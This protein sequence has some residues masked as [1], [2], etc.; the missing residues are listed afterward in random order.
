[1]PSKILQMI[2]FVA[3]AT[4]AGCSS[5]PDIQ[6]AEKRIAKLIE[7]RGGQNPVFRKVTSPRSGAVCGEV[8]FIALSG[9]ESADWRYHLIDGI[10]E[11]EPS[12]PFMPYTQSQKRS[13]WYDRDRVCVR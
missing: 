13:G 8:R 12:P 1:M 7:A 5:N 10:A 9:N 11:I 4:I 6:Q 3:F 2:V